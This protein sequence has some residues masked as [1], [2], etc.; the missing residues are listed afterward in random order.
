MILVKI[1]GGIDLISSL[2]FLMLIFGINP[3]FQIML[4]CGG[5][6][7]MKS[8]FI[9]TGEPLSIIDLVSSILL[10]LSIFLTLPALFLWVPAFLLLAKGIVSFI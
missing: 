3:F 4:F 5:L 9:I 1:L 10:F 6:L 8:M 2:I 7:L